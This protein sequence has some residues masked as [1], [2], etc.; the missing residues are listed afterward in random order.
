MGGGK[1]ISWR[2]IAKIF[3]VVA[4]SDEACASADVA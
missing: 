2:Q 4:I 3:D 1:I